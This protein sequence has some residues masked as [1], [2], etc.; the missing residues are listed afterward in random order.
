[1]SRKMILPAL[2][3]SAVWGLPSLSEAGPPDV[4]K[5]TATALFSQVFTGTYRPGQFKNIFTITPS[6]SLV[7]PSDPRSESLAEN[8]I[9]I[10]VVLRDRVSDPVAGFNDIE[11]RVGAGGEFCSDFGPWR[12]ETPTDS[13]GVAFF[14][15]RVPGWGC[16]QE[17]QVWVGGLFLNTVPVGFNSPDDLN[18]SSGFVDAADLAAFAAAFGN[19]AKYTICM[20]FNED[21]FVDASDL[22]HFSNAL[23]D[24]CSSAPQ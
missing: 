6:F 18:R 2:V 22:A 9:A 3:L 13:L 16:V 4:S 21:G 19:P 24:A 15:G 20:D 5:S 8:G 11:I 7:P 10:K 17:L 14:T 23:G 1:M 12:P